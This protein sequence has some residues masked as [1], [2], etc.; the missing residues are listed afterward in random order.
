VSPVMPLAR[1][2][3]GVVVE[4]RKAKS[5]WVDFVWRP[6]AV[7]PGLPE[8]EPWTVLEQGPETAMIYA[9]AADIAL[10]R[11]ET[12]MYRDN[13]ATGEPLL[14]VVL[15]PTDIDPPYEL[16]TVTADPSEGE[17]YTAAGNDLVDSVPMPE[18]I[19]EA[20]EAFIAMHHVEQPFVKRKRDSADPDAMARRAPAERKGHEE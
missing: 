15:R 2:P 6:V 3:A 18:S 16:I 20:I 8:A 4:R 11:S 5:Q 14:W 7:L 12:A 19:R 13:L 10:Y 9:G 17:G 1:I